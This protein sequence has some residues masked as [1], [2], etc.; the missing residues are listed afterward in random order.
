M[1]ITVNGQHYESPDE[2]PAEVRRQ[3]D[4]AMRAIGPALPA[5]TVSDST[6]VLGGSAGPGVHGDVVIR[7]TIMVNQQ[8]FKSV[9]EMP[10]EARR[11]YENAVARATTEGAASA[12]GLHLTLRVGRPKL[13]AFVESGVST[14]P[15][16]IEPSN[17]ARHLLWHLV[18]WV[19]LALVLW[20]F[21]RR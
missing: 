12:P 21:L 1:G 17:G 20:A 2:M 16:P 3:Y 15:R 8:T 11:L 4:E 5:G 7:K 19:A 6:H 13:R 9:D 18:F 10:L 14:P